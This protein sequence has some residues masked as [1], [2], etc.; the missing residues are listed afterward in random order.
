MELVEIVDGAVEP[1]TRARFAVLIKEH[2]L[3]RVEV[4]ATGTLDYC[5]GTAVAYAAE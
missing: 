5:F 3:G 4:M 1:K 2:G